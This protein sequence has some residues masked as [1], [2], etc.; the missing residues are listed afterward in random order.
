MKN[1]KSLLALVLAV[2]LM[3]SLAVTAFAEDVSVLS[4]PAETT[5]ATETATEGAD[6]V[7]EAPAEDEGAEADTKPQIEAEVVAPED[8]EGAETTGAVETEEVSGG[9]KALRVVL[10][11]LEVIASLIMVIV[12]LLQS[13]KEAGL[14]GAIS[15]NSDSYANKNGLSRDKKLAKA[16]K[17]VAIA[18]LVLT[19][20][21]SLLP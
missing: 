5:A 8:V 10:T 17:W 3:M 2:C 21:L 4:A 13:G 12:I 14:S 16:T 1:I 7:E 18:W 15:G 9:V 11:V 19:L 6:E 20:A